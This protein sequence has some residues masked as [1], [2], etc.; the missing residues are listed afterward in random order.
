MRRTTCE[1]LTFE[2][3]PQAAALTT[4]ELRRLAF[5]KLDGILEGKHHDEE[6]EH[7][8]NA[9]KRGHKPVGATRTLARWAM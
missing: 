7:D 8:K 3:E 6:V 2:L 9:A 5:K 4:V 1:T